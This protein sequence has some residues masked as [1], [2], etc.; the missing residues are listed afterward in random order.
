MDLDYFL[1]GIYNCFDKGTKIITD[2]GTFSFE[3]LGENAEINVPTHTGEWKKAIVK[4][5]GVQDLY[6]MTFKRQ[7]GMTKEVICTDN[8]RWILDDGK[9]TTNLKIG[10][11]LQETPIIEDF[12]IENLSR[13]EKES[14][15]LG[16]VIGDG[17]DYTNKGSYGC[18]VR[19]CG[20]KNKYRFI[21]DELGYGCFNVNDDT[22]DV[23]YIMPKMRKQEFLDNKKYKELN[24]NQ[25]IALINGLYCA[26]ASLYNGNFKMF[27]SVDSRILDMVR[28]LSEVAGYYL[29]GEFVVEGTTNYAP[30][31]R[32][33]LT[34]IQFNK[35]QYR[36]KWRLIK[37][38]YLKKDVVW[39]L[40]VEDNHSF[41]LSNGMV[42]GNCELVN[43][44]DMLQN[45]TVINKKKI[46]TPKSLRTAMTLV[47]QIAA[48]V[49][50]C[51][52]GGQTIT[53][54]HIAPF[55]RVSR[56][57][58]E[59]KYRDM[60]LPIVEEKLQELIDKELRDEIKDSV[61]TFNYQISTLNSTNGQII[62][63]L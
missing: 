53:L 54:S 50:S 55:V 27:T 14:W 3:E 35:K 33:P 21:F 11:R 47:T 49:S 37:K 10:D 44:E 1:Q 6:K 15:V 7:N 4:S 61:Q 34:Y 24:K 62:G 60:N 58:I 28:E 46:D 2:R 16:F 19:L 41:I 43:L 12:D 17:T 23:I 25:K 56:N 8:H 39:C 42:T 13:E 5:Y 31:G 38:E 9:V 22:D 52:Y 45:G 30:N 57:K 63:R 18:Q 59:K 40:E 36:V 29:N 32:K 20:K 51:T 26:D 48:Q